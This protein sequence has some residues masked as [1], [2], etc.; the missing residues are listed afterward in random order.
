MKYVIETKLPTELLNQTERAA[1]SL[2]LATNDYLQQALHEK[3]GQWID[4]QLSQES[5]LS[6]SDGVPVRTMLSEEL[7]GQV[8]RAAADFGLSADD[9]LHQALQEK[10]TRLPQDIT[11]K[12]EMDRAIEHI[13]EKNGEL[14]CRLAEWPKGEKE[15][16][17]EQD[18]K[19]YA[20][21]QSANP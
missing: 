4:N 9:F 12:E 6:S 15:Q 2:S 3:V 7:M 21:K 8:E 18:R 10:V 17:Q 11:H 19:Q 5:R 20:T 1:R 13:F 16:E 14:F